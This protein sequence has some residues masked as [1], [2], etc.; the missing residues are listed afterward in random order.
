MSGP[1]K[2]STPSSGKPENVFVYIERLRQQAEE[3]L[4]TVEEERRTTRALLEELYVRQAKR[5][6]HGGGNYR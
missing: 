3:F 5:R 6:G 4:R 1:L 2:K